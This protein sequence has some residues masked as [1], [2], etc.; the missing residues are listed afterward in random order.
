M[1]EKGP[2][3]LRRIRNILESPAYQRAD[4]DVN[5]L[6][7]NDVRGTRLQLDYLKTELNLRRRGIE[8]TIVVFGSTRIPD[9]V[10]AK[11]RL[12]ELHAA[13]QKRP[14]DV[15]LAEELQVAE[16]ILAKSSYYTVAREFAALVA[17]SGEGPDDTRVTIMTGGGP[18]IMEAANR[19]A[20]ETGSK[21][22]GLNIT[23]PHE[24]YP[25]SYISE[26]LA[27]S[28]HYFAVRKLHF[29]LRARALVAFPGGF[30][31]LDEVFETL[32][33]VQTGTIEPLPVVLV[34]EEFWRR[35]FDPD[36]L[37]SEGVIAAQDRLLFC[38]A[39][40]ADQIWTEICAWHRGAGQALL[41][42]LPGPD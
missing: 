32:T 4:R 10:E 11:E 23:L 26:D 22:I 18:G 35:A 38:Y 40:T 17:K 37:V 36:F 21:S 25:N 12:D 13:L 33:L 30:G 39:E 8:Q 29:L 20:Y 34:G 5:F 2:D 15:E 19:G 1:T 27:F 9:P 28:V 6:D 31:T 14:D 24:Q 3:A 41:C 16:R 7:E 42:D